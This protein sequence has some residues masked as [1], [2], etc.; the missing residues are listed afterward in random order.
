MSILH[1]NNL[2]YAQ[3]LSLEQANIALESEFVCLTKVREILGR[4]GGY[5]NLDS[6]SIMKITAGTLEEAIEGIQTMASIFQEYDG[7]VEPGC[8]TDV[9]MKAFIVRA[10]AWVR[11]N[12]V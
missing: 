10:N 5:W 2:S 8:Q 11:V 7:D 3:V 9:Q 1:I 6:R 4:M 12:R